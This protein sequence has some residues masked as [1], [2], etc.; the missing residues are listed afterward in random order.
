MHKENNHAM[1][2]KP[3][4]HSRI[5][6]L[7][8]SHAVGSQDQLRALLEREGF[9]VTQAT[10]SRDLRA[11]GVVKG[12]GGYA[13][14]SDRGFAGA[15]AASAALSEVLAQYALRIEAA[16]Q[17]VVVRTGAGHA[18]VVAL[19]ID[20]SGEDG[21]VGTIAG[22]DTIFVACRDASAASQTAARW[23]AS[24]GIEA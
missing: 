23:R 8:R 6:E 20:R 22:D 11:L 10:L 1:P 9:R 12:P 21:V 18:Q 7:L 15:G 13:L 5:V 4:R 19:A 2:G 3:R 24:G 16:G 14:A 17:L